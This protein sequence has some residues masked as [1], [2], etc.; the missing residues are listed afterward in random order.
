MTKEEFKTA[1]TKEQPPKTD[2]KIILAL[3]YDSKGNWEKAHE[4][5]RGVE[6]EI[7][8]WVHAY[9][10]RKQKDLSNASCWYSRARRKL[11]DL[12]LHEEWE[13]IA[14]YLFAV[15]EANKS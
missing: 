11:P 14:D 8:Y 1:L 5:I 13:E 2:N 10:H 4:S 12:G 7:A 9:L 3:W 15:L 6:D